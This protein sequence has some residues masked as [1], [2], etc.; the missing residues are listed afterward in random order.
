MT[1]YLR[2]FVTKKY[3][4]CI[5]KLRPYKF[6]PVLKTVIWGGERIL[7]FKGCDTN[8]HGVGES[9]ELSG[10]DGMESVV[11]GGQ[12]DG[13]TLT[14]LIDR[15][16]AALLGER[17]YRQC[18][19]HFPLLVKLIDAHRDLSVQVHPDDAMAQRMHGCSGKTEMWYV[20]DHEPGAQIMAGFSQGITPEEYDRRVADGSMMDVVKHHTS[21]NGQVYFLPA[22]CIHAIGAGNFV[23]EIQQSSDIT[24]RVFDYNRLDKDGHPRQLH[25]AQ[26]REALN[27][28]T[29]DECLLQ[30]GA[31]ICKGGVSVSCDNFTVERLAVAGAVQL[32]LPESF[33]V[34][35]C[36]DGEVEILD[37]TGTVTT[38]HRG[39]TILV[40]ACLSQLT[41]HGSATLLTAR[42]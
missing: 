2:S 27:Y 16:G 35:M 36:V 9:W 40:P 8:L 19:N 42:S 31:T 21:H 17:V 18:G 13:L 20:I 11:D 7:A 30:S 22:G 24:Y 37:E 3:Y 23:A 5:M 29:Y 12:D 34:V 28:S 32:D 6:R 14:Q 41:L 1:Q 25:T 33:L 38:L 15:H 39:Q 10:I 26:A 4:F